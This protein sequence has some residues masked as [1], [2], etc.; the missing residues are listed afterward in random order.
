MNIILTLLAGIYL[1]G[2]IVGIIDAWIHGANRTH[3]FLGAFVWPLSVAVIAAHS[4]NR[5][6]VR[7]K[8]SVPTV[9]ETEVYTQRIRFLENALQASATANAIALGIIGCETM[10]G[11][12][13]NSCFSRLDEMNTLAREYQTAMERAG[14]MQ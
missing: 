5:D 14:Y 7:K 11:Q 6:E 3:V 10:R 8:L 12:V 9:L 4:F 13:C 2:A 1:G